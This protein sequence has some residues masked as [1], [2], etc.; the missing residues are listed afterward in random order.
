MSR[1]ITLRMKT[2][3]GWARDI[4]SQHG[5]VPPHLAGK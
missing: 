1:T 5:V 2:L 4:L 3:Q